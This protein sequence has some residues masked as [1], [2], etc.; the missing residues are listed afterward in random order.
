MHNKARSPSDSGLWFEGCC[1][2]GRLSFAIVQKL[3]EV[4]P[5]YAQN[6][7]RLA[8]GIMAGNFQQPRR[9]HGE[10]VRG[11]NKAQD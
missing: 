4:L 1:V 6:R 5:F 11:R 7:F 9:C 8:V 10:F 3:A 2:D